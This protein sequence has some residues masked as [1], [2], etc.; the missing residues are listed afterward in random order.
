M[1]LLTV[2][3]VPLEA[4]AGSGYVISGYVQ[5]LRARGHEVTT[6]EPRD[7]LPWPSRRGAHR[8]RMLLGYT[9]ATHRAVNRG[10][11]DVV[12][13]W[14]A[15]S[16]LVA[17]QLAARPSRPFLV[18][19]SNGLETHF[20]AALAAHGAAQPGLAGRLF[21]RWQSPA[22]AF[23]RVDALTVVSRFDADY[24]TAAG[25]QPPERLLHLDNP[26]PPEWLGQPLGPA[27][28][29]VL[30][31]FGAW[32]ENKGRALLPEIF[33]AALRAAPKWRGL[34]VGPPAEA[35]T[36]FAP[37]LRARL[38]FV[39]FTSDKAHLRELYRGCAVTLLP[40]AYESFGL[41]AAEALACGCALVASP[42][43]FAA[44]LRDG[45]EALLVRE[46]SVRAWS[47]ALVPLLRDPARRA[48]LA[49]AGHARVQALAWPATVD[50]LEA[51]YAARLAALQPP[52]RPS[53]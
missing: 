10:R 47:E 44:G 4:S 53:A 48:Q 7:Y 3:N 14:G 15:E 42:V 49:A 36:A 30:G 21:D 16:W 26:L 52:A 39:P 40:S 45:E 38:T 8:L 1:R 25:Y 5:H 18:G 6:L 35:P 33:A 32:L 37:E 28:P 23:R 41:V 13:L 31:F 34:I 9:R 27:R 43:G 46:R 29:P 20:R 24:A 11:F 2:S 51:F 12:E 19:R 50:R 22:D 17:R